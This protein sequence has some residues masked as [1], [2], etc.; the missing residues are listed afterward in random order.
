MSR[1]EA[2][3]DAEIRPNR[4]RG[5]LITLEGGEGA[6]KSTQQ[7]LILQKL[8][9]AG[10]QA[11]ATREPGGSPMAE[12][13]RRILLSGAAVSLGPVA[14]TLLF[15]AARIDHLD[16]K[17]RPA[18]ARGI[19][20]VCDRFSD[21]TRAYQGAHGQVAPEFILALERVSLGDTVPD[22]TL[23]LDLPPETGL[24][25]AAARRGKGEAVDRFESEGLAFHGALQASFRAIAAAEPQRCALIDASG[26]VAAVAEKIW[27]TIARRLLS[28]RLRAR[29]GGLSLQHGPKLGS[30]YEQG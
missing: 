24:A 30:P 9:E 17:I 12:E 4:R 3:A 10:I 15:A 6:G 11:I 5:R 28:A 26:D 21:S 29:A 7:D 25:R 16:S 23:I 22:L 8:K 20:V 18:L 27:S 2:Q 13:L 1:L 14:E 19:W